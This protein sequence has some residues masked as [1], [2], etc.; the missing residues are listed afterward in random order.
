MSGTTGVAR[1]DTNVIRGNSFKF[2]MTLAENWSTDYLDWTG[3]LVIREQQQ[4]EL[5]DLFIVSSAIDPGD[6][7]TS[8]PTAIGSLTF[9]MTPTQ[10]QALPPYDLVYFIEL[11]NPGD[12]EIER[13]IQGRVE[14]T[15]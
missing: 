7:P 1:H 14:V 12:S 6:I 15:D 11:R 4:D 13:L 5:S 8:Y 9:N 3:R 2:Y 10:T